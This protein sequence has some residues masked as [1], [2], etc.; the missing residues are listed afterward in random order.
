VVW[1]AR[2]LLYVA[3]FG[4]AIPFLMLEGIARLLPVSSPPP[5]EPVS[6]RNP[7][8]RF[9]PNVDYVYSAGPEFA[10]RSRKHS[11]NHGYNNRIDYDPAARLPLL[12]VVGDSFVEAHEVDAG[13]SAAELLHAGLERRGRVYSFG[14]SGGALPQ[15][16]MYAQHARQVFNARALAFVIIGNDFDESLLKYKDEPRLHYFDGAGKIRRVDYELSATKRVLRES[17]FIRYV[18]L[19]MIANYRLEQIRSLLRGRASR[20]VADKPSP[21]RMLDRLAD[22]RQAVDWFFAHLPAMTGLPPSAIMFVVD[23]ERPALYSEAALA[24]SRTQ[25]GYQRQMVGYFVEKARAGG[26]EVLDMERAFIR[27]HRAQGVRFEFPT[28]RHWN[29]AGQRVV[30]AEMAKSAT[31]TRLFGPQRPAPSH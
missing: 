19:N 28:D 12:A 10:I 27:E 18:M 1:L 20:D 17:A 31:F 8:A 3:I 7:L 9:P 16:L 2:N 14:V 5:L 25:N 24:Q 23:G 22:S 13:K 4:V 30:A 15:Y 11:N 26:Y 21:E 6:A 29:E